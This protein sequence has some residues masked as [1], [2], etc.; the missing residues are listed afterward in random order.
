MLCSLCVYIKEFTQRT[1]LLLSSSN[2]FRP[3]MISSSKTPNEKTSVFSSTIPCMK[4]SGAKYLPRDCRNGEISYGDLNFRMIHNKWISIFVTNPNVPSN[5][6][7][8]WW[9]NCF[10]NHLA[11]PKSQIYREH[12]T[13][14]KQWVKKK[15]RRTDNVVSESNLRLKLL[16]KKDIVGFNI[17][18]NDSPLAALMK[19]QKTFRY[20]ESNLVPFPPLQSN[21]WT[22]KRHS[23]EESNQNQI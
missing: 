17:S 11:S 16:G 22:W 14:I 9:V 15:G 10:G 2:A 23:R 3:V 5:F 1:R 8:L 20:S 18:M 19:I 4:Y 12:T 21:V 6:D 7:T 13:L